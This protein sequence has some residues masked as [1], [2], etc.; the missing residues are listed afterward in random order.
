[1]N[2]QKY[3]SVFVSALALSVLAPTAFAQVGPNWNRYDLS[4]K[5]GGLKHHFEDQEHNPNRSERKIK[6][7]P[8]PAA[9]LEFVSPFTTTK[10]VIADYRHDAALETETFRLIGD[11]TVAANRNEVRLQDDYGVGEAR[12]FEGYVTFG[13]NVNNQCLLQIWGHAV[14]AKAAQLMMDGYAVNNGSLRFSG[15]PGVDYYG[16]NFWGRE[17]KINVIHIQES[18]TGVAGRIQVYV[19]G[20]LVV[21][22]A[23]EMLTL[24]MKPPGG[25]YMKYG[26]YGGVKKG[27]ENPE[28][29]VWKNVRYFRD[30]VLAGETAQAI[31]RFDEMPAK[32]LGDAPFDPGAQADS[33]LPVRYRSDNL[34][35]ARITSDQRVEIVGKGTATIWAIQDGNA[36]YAPAP[37]RKQTLIVGDAPSKRS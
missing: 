7:N 19:D 15:V 21:N 16:G 23:D 4:A 31:A 28:S 5:P 33:G 2:P 18:S 3:T 8:L 26:I 25:N 29:V 27:F 11:H 34:A 9:F 12:Q 36:T 10:A 24:N 22:M 6:I 32:Q 37:V 14:S 1:M 13:K 35:V 17:L 20:V 30:G